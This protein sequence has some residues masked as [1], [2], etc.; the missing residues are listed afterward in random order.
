MGALGGHCLWNLCWD[1]RK[2]EGKRRI[3]LDFR[4]QWWTQGAVCWR[5]GGVCAR[6]GVKGIPTISRWNASPFECPSV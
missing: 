2:V 4:I 5:L 1:D 3:D 6:G